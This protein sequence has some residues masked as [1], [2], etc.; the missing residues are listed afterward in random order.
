VA[1]SIRGFLSGGVAHC[2]LGERGHAKVGGGVLTRDEF[3]DLGE[4]L[5]APARLT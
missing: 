4:L 3:V 5:A 1:K 2:D